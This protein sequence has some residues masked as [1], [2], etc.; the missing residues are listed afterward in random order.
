MKIL[1]LLLFNIVSQETIA[2]PKVF[3]PTPEQRERGT[4]E[5]PNPGRFPGPI[6]RPAEPKIPDFKLPF[7]PNVPDFKGPW[8]RTPT[9]DS[10]ASPP[11]LHFYDKAR[12][13]LARNGMPVGHPDA[14][15]RHN[16][17]GPL[18]GRDAKEERLLQASGRL[19]ERLDADYHAQTAGTRAHQDHL[20]NFITYKMP[21]IADFQRHFDRAFPKTVPVDMLSQEQ[22]KVTA[23]F[24]NSRFQTAMLFNMV[25]NFEFQREYD[26]KTRKESQHGQSLKLGLEHRNRAGEQLKLNDPNNSDKI[27]LLDRADKSLDFAD[28]AF[29]DDHSDEGQLAIDIAIMLAD[30]TI[31]VTPVVGWGRDVYESFT[32]RDLVKGTELST[33]ERSIAILGVSTLGV[34][35]VAAKGIKVFKHLAGKNGLNLHTLLNATNKADDIVHFFDRLDLPTDKIKD[36]AVDLAS[37]KRRGHILYGD[38]TG[39]GHLWPGSVKHTPFPKDWDGDR[40]MHEISDIATDPKIKWTQ[41]KPPKGVRFVAIRPASDGSTY[42]KVVM[43]PVGEGIITGY[44]VT[45]NQFL[46]LNK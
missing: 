38:G 11:P 8:S 39:G 35:S 45:K 28:Q 26:F 9:L 2:N 24:L 29:E 41:Q 15:P 42:V 40:I 14:Q 33:V 34:T 37:P 16:G 6:P 3:K 10:Y 44:P 21:S 12:P 18:G 22:L 20:E 36:Y 19:V 27:Y 32:G 17:G 23:S 4:T 5:D 7:P 46:E 43:E 31:S 30:L 13:A 25:D 1:A